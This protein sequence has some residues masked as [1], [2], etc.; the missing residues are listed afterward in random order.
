M[1]SYPIGREITINHQNSPPQLQ[2]DHTTRWYKGAEGLH[3]LK[4]ALMR[5]LPASWIVSLGPG[6]LRHHIKLSKYESEKSFCIERNRFSFSWLDAFYSAWKS[7]RLKLSKLSTQ[8][9][10]FSTCRR[11]EALQGKTQVVRKALPESFNE[12]MYVYVFFL[13]MCSHCLFIYTQTR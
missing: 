6:S 5:L 8:T 13:W 2:L 3:P 4:S 7:C 10:S 9:W 11:T 12:R 1:N